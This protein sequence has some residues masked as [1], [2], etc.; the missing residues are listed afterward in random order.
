MGTG[1]LGVAAK[2]LCN[3][4]CYTWNEIC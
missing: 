3:E 2:V 1:Y 4:V